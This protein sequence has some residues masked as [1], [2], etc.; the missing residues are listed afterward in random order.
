[1]SLRAQV[2][3]CPAVVPFVAPHVLLG[4]IGPYNRIVKILFLF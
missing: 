4:Q 3:P 1:M 2:T